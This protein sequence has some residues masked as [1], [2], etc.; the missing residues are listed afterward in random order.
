MG[1]ARL[2]A[3]AWVVLCIFAGAHA[4]RIALASGLPLSSTAIALGICVLLF[5]AMGLLFVGGFGVSGGI[6]VPFAARLKPAHWIPG[7]NEIVFV[8]FLILSFVDQAVFA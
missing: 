2:L 5:M 7:F 4:L 6:G 1:I 8:A 3:K